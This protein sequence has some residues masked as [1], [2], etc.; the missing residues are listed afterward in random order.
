LTV[1][2]LDQ[3]IKDPSLRARA[4]FYHTCNVATVG[5][6]RG[7]MFMCDQV[8]DQFQ[9]CLKYWNDKRKDP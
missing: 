3:F 5:K 1:N 8:C 6:I 2:R 7:P 9:K 4:K